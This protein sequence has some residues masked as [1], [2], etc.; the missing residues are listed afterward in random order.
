MSDDKEDDL[1]FLSFLFSVLCLFSVRFLPSLSLSLSEWGEE[2]GSVYWGMTMRRET[3]Y[4][5]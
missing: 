5:L 2:D 1:L 3:Q 4:F